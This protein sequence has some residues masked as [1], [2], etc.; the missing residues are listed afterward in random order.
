MYDE[1]HEEK[2]Y[3]YT[4]LLGRNAT[5]HVSQPKERRKKKK[6]IINKKV[7]SSPEWELCRQRR[8]KPSKKKNKQLKNINPLR[9]DMR[10]SMFS[11]MCT[12][13]L[14][15]RQFIQTQQHTVFFPIQQGR[16][17]NDANFIIINSLVRWK[18][19]L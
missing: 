4:F 7:R 3:E 10:P 11:S 19:V 14:L 8:E 18:R 13:S 6:I 5:K 1:Y 12:Q 15:E 9:V 17:K 2:D 16:S